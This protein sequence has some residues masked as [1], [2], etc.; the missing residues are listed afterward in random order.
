MRSIPSPTPR[1]PASPARP[2]ARL[3]RLACLGDSITYGH[4]LRDESGDYSYPAVL[5]RLLG[6]EWL[7]R[8]F[9]VSG[10]TL[11]HRGDNPYMRTE[12]FTAALIFKPDVVVIKLGTNDSKRPRPG[13]MNAPDNWRHKTD[14]AADYRDLITTLRKAHPS[15]AVFTCLPVPA[16]PGNWGIDDATLRDEVGPLVRAVSSETGAYL[17]DL[18]SALSG[19]PDCFPDTVHPNSAG[20]ALIATTVYR[21]VTA[22]RSTN[23]SA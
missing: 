4:G 16:Y 1:T 5:A 6:P 22:W 19:R 23:T 11:L 13:V 2:S 14:Y 8:N 18:Y 7:V 9:G 20:A 21:H 12:A 3:L 10:T 15:V 17:I